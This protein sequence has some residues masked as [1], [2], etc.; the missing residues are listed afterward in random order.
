MPFRLNHLM[1]IVVALSLSVSAA[2]AEEEPQG[3]AKTPSGM[4]VPRFVA[5]KSDEVNVRSGPGT[6]YPI[7]YVYKRE[8]MPVEVVD[9]FDQWRK[10]RDIEGSA[11]WV[12]KS[13]VDGKRTVMIAA[14][15]PEMLRLDAD[16][17]SRPVLRLAPKVIAKLLSCTKD[18]CRVSVENHKGWIK[19]A[20]LWGV[21]KDEKF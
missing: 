18:W 6:R 2:F 11:G 7:S 14:K 13:M 21:Y 10:V 17:K 20:A 1:A 5:L 15:Q 8:A 16:E 3:D 9:E 12:H 4:P 19:K